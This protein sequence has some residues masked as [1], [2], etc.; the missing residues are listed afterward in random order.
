MDRASGGGGGGTISAEF[1]EMVRQLPVYSKE[2][3]VVCA[4]TQQNDENA[5]R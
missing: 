2:R 5:T 3:I 4:M 1:R